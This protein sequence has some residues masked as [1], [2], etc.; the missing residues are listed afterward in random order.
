MTS[1]PDDIKGGNLHDAD[2][3]FR[4]LYRRLGNLE[5]AQYQ[6]VCRVCEYALL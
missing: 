2:P 6:Q 4:K 5:T 1:N 3:R